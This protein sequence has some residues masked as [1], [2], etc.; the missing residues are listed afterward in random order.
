MNWLDYL[1][2]A[3]LV[4][5]T[6]AG[7]MRGLLREVIALVTWVTAVWLAW[8]CSDWIAPH[9][10]GLLAYEGVRT[11]AA[12]AIVF[13]IVLLV[14]SAIALIVSRLVRL[15]LFS[16]TDRAFG[17]L[18]GLLRGLIML[19]LFVILCHAV[20]LEDESWWRGSILVPYAEHV[21]NVLR[22]MVGERKIEP[23]SSVTAAS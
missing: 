2:L 20:R 1:L 5:S 19:G 10:G 7:L 22:S 4:F 14:G 3:L 9:L 21:A 8:T 18:F 17:A 11:W 16:G 13:I 12:R 23:G 15:S 6:V